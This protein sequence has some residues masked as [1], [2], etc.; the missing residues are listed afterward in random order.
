MSFEG[1]IAHRLESLDAGTI[2]VTVDYR[3]EV[4]APAGR[5]ETRTAKVRIRNRAP[6]YEVLEWT[7]R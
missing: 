6:D 1:F 2:E 5:R 3:A 4:A 7:A